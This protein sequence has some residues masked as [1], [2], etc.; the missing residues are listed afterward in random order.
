MAQ[1]TK[2]LTDRFDA[3]LAMASQ[4]HRHQSRKGT[5]I[6]YVAHVLGVAVHV[7]EHGGSE[8]Q[9]I[10]ALLHDAIEDAPASIGANEV[11]RQIKSE[12]GDAVL[13]IVEHCTD[14]DV[15]PKPP[16]VQ[17]KT[18][19]LAHLQTAP[20]DALLVSAADKLHN[21]QALLRD[22]RA[23]GE[24]LWGRFNKEAGRTGMLGYYRALVDTFTVRLKNDIVKELETNLEAL[25]AEAHGP[26]PW[27]PRA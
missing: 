2:P 12:F 3:A 14:T 13:A 26:C 1:L 18:T 17:R 16:W 24:G 7:L 19:Y 20:D 8:V 15:Q 22:Y 9:A 6:P 4:I 25:E 27:P 11:R 5:E 23:V 21:V 10:A